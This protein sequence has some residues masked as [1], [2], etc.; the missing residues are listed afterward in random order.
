MFFIVVHL[1]FK[2]STLIS[3]KHQTYPVVPL[4]GNLQIFHFINFFSVESGS[5]AIGWW[6]FCR[7]VGTV[8]PRSEMVG[9]WLCVSKCAWTVCVIHRVSLKL[10]KLI[11]LFLICF[12]WIKMTFLINNCWFI[13]YFFIIQVIFGM[14]SFQYQWRSRWI[15][16]STYSWNGRRHLF[17]GAM[18]L[19][20]LLFVS[21]IIRAL[22]IKINHLQINV[23]Q[24]K[25]YKLQKCL[26]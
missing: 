15:V 18:Y 5:V 16:N 24:C 13:S 4:F 23:Y 22:T 10:F 1:P 25:I 12:V 9:W 2:S 26:L 6:R 19:G 14:A 7:D 11:N 21:Y 8:C 3:S 17:N 20:I